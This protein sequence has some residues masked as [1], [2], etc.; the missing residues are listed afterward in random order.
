MRK[1][2]AA[3]ARA[4]GDVNDG[5]RAG[6]EHLRNDEARAQVGA[7]E[8]GIDRVAPILHQIVLYRLGG[9][10]VPRVVDERVNLPERGGANG[11]NAAHI[12][13]KACIGDHRNGPAAGTRHLGG[14]CL[15][16]VGR[17]GGANDSR[18][19]FGKAQAERASDALRGSR[20]QGDSS[21]Q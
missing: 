8:T 13:L 15:H 4:G 2:Q 7:G 18:T 1:G 17:A 12:I 3:T 10:S 14:C 21:I 5:A 16:L 9:A 11:H 19:L 6:L 20:D